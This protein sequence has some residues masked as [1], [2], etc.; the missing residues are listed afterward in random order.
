MGAFGYLEIGL[1]DQTGLAHVVQEL[2]KASVVFQVRP[3]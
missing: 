3:A 1:R 2:E